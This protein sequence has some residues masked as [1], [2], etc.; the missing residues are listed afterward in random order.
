MDIFRNTRIIALDIETTGVNIEFDRIIELGV[1]EYENGNLIREYT[2]LFSGGRSLPYLVKS[3]HGIRD[4]DRKKEKTFEES[5]EKVASYL[6][7]AYLLGHNI[8]KFDKPMIDYKLSLGGCKLENVKLIDT[9]IL[10]R[11]FKF[12]SNTLE[13]L[14][15]H[16]NLEY[17]NHRGLGDSKTCYELFLKLIEK[18]DVKDLKEIT[19]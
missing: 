12:A 13:W 4:R 19:I 18:L 7:N 17:G 15:N 1:V 5:A 8:K 2:K 9:L 11:K 3:I 16:F 14:A 6:S 10:A